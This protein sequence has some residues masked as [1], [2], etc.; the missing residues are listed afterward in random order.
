MGLK[1]APGHVHLFVSDDGPGI[2]A[3]E[4]MKVF[5]R[6]Y[7]LDKSRNSPGTGLGLSL[8]KAV[9]ELHGGTVTLSDNGPGLTCTVRFPAAG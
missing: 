9:G 4:R 7:R 1:L 8:V 2:P 3:G 6:F 5:D